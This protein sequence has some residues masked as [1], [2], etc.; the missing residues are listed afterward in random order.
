MVKI[1]KTISKILLSLLLCIAVLFVVMPSKNAKAATGTVYVVGVQLSEGDVLPSNSVEKTTEIPSEGGYAMLK[2]GVLTLNNYQYEGS[3]VYKV[4]TDNIVIHS[5]ADLT[6]NLVGNNVI[7]TTAPK[8]IGINAVDALTI[9]SEAG[10]ILKI[11]GTLACII[12]AGLNITFNNVTVEIK[13]SVAEFGLLTAGKYISQKSNL[14]IASSG[15]AMW[16]SKASIIEDGEIIIKHPE[17]VKTTVGI[18]SSYGGLTVNGGKVSVEASIAALRVRKLTVNGGSV[19]LSTYNLTKDNWAIENGNYEYAENIRLV[20]SKNSYGSEAEYE[21]KSKYAEYKYMRFTSGIDALEVEFDPNGGTGEMN[22]LYANNSFILPESKFTYEPMYVFAGWQIGDKVY[23]PG[24]FL[25]DTGHV[26]AKAV[27]KK[28]SCVDEDKN[29]ECDICKE[30]VGEH[31]AQE[32]THICEYCNKEASTCVDEDKNHECDI[33]KETMGEHIAQ[34][35]THICEYCN[36]EASTCVDEDKNHECDICKETVG[37]HIAQEGTH[38][39]EYCN[40]E[41]STCVDEDKDDKC[42]ICKKELTEELPPVD[43]PTSDE[44]ILDCSTQ[45]LARLFAPII[46]LSL[47]ILIIRKKK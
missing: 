35:G 5:N 3:D 18:A 37:E 21:D 9:T 28:H 30:I 17:D 22:N 38:T 47:L 40:K 32:G 15:T 1:K 31:I 13:S 11:D 44:L 24:D 34:E 20:V 6:I 7:T 26:A 27:W 12:N 41:A 25:Q 2:D 23:Q 10:G 4:S 36:K 42:D 33:C 8:S 16:I 19:L 39:C 29:H 45:T 46:S 14:I 43:D